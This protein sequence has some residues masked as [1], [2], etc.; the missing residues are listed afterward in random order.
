MLRPGRRA[1]NTQQ[2]LQAWVILLIVLLVASLEHIVLLDMFKDRLDIGAA[3]SSQGVAE[4]SFGFSPPVFETQLAR[5]ETR[6]NVCDFQRSYKNLSRTE[7]TILL[8]HLIV[9]P[10]TRMIY[11]YVPKVACTNWKNTFRRLQSPNY[12][13]PEWTEHNEGMKLLSTY[14]RKQAELMLRTYFKFVFV[15]HPLSRLISAFRDKFTNEPYMKE[16]YGVNI[17]KE[18]REAP[19]N[20]KVTGDDVTFSEFVC[21]LLRHPVE[22]FNEHWMPAYKLCQPCSINYN[23]IGK[24]E[25]LEEDANAV[26]HAVVPE[27]GLSFPHRQAKY[28]PAHNEEKIKLMNEI[29]STTMEQLETVFDLDY[30]IFSYDKK[31][32]H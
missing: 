32:T 18:C 28:R 27:S 6:W 2:Q 12:D 20:G 13:L 30:R 21:Y 19:T 11:C 15:R 16:R 9:E 14:P 7:Q 1:G 25:H 22:E 31:P 17:I 8:N 5:N 24:Y 10:N 29:S 4:N 3:L 23:Y 26:L